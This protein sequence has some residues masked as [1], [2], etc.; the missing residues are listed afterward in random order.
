MA[1][2]SFQVSIFFLLFFINL[3]FYYIIDTVTKSCNNIILRYYIKNIFNSFFYLLTIKVLR[4]WRCQE[5][6]GANHKLIE[7]KWLGP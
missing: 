1:Y 4:P 7:T 3:F 5:V 6:G 2:I